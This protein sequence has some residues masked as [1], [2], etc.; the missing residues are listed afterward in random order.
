MLV[1][2]LLEAEKGLP[3]KLRRQQAFATG[4]P[5]NPL[6]TLEAIFAII[7]VLLIV[8]KEERR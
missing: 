3:A 6:L 1:G 5:V 7:C 4:S 2:L 8:P